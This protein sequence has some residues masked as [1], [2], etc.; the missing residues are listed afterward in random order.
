VQIRSRRQQLYQIVLTRTGTPAP[1][2]RRGF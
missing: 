2:N 1:R